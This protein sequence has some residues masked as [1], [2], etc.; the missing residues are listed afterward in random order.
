MFRME[1]QVKN[2]T[3]SLIFKPWFKRVFPNP[4]IAFVKYSPAII[5]HKTGSAT[6]F[7]IHVPLKGLL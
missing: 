1:K 5:H 7:P 2:Q 4:Y 6:I 3:R